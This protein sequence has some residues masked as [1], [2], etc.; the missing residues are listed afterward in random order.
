[1]AKKKEKV[2]SL[3][4]EYKKNGYLY[5][6]IK[7]NDKAALYEQRNIKFPEDTSIGY[8]VFSI[9]ISPACVLIGKSGP[10]KGK[11]YCYP[12]SEKFPGNEDFGKNAWFLK[13]KKLANQKF[14]E[15][16]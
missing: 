11:E 12:T 7:R 13:S 16:S 4:Q 5:T 3:K 1:M 9:K 14:K 15:I 6:L 10:T 8:E 2:Q